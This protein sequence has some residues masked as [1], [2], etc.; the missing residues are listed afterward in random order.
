MPLPRAVLATAVLATSVLAR[1]IAQ[2]KLAPLDRAAQSWVE[3]TLKKMTLDE[4]IGQLLVTTL[5]ASFT[6]VDSDAFAKLR[7][8]ARDV[9]VGGIHVFGA[10]E[11]MPAL[12]L[13]STYGAGGGA[14]RKGDPY[15]AAALLNRLQ[16]EA[17]VPLLTTADFEGGVGYMMNGATRLPRAMAIGATRDAELAYRAGKVSAEEGRALGVCVDFYPIVDVNNN[18]RNP[19]INIRSFAEDVK[20]V[21][22]MA[23]A[24]I[25]GVRDGAM[26]ATAKHFPGHGDTATDTHLGLAV[27]EHPRSHLETIELPP[28]QAAIDAG[29]GAVMSSHIAL[30]ALDPADVPGAARRL[31]TPATLSR[32]ILTGL[33][34]DQM[35]FDGLI[36][37]DSMSMLAISQNVPPDRAAALAV[38]AGADQVL[39][40]PDDDA[41]FRGIRAAVEAGEIAEAQ[42]ARSVERVLAAKARMGLHATRGVDLGL[43]DERLGTREHQQV[44]DDLC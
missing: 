16:S 8:L 44:A 32:P 38:R 7:H 21:S 30:P 18:A 4:K 6:S 27:I 5:N 24:Y 35:K 12:L 43:I 10:T 1:P 2:T 28:F 31:P 26:I 25:R 11:P 9:K 22:D 42:I 19:I 37:T 33:L 13:N 17:E 29:A 23:R 3:Q 20:L 39:H 15:V 14:S 34:R 36:Y 40:S 41:A